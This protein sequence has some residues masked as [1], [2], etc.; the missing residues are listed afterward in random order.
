MIF[1]DQETEK[2]DTPVQL[3]FH[4][5]DRTPAFIISTD[6]THASIDLDKLT[7]PPHPAKVALR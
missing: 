4:T 7:F 2:I 1:I 6:P 5:A 3:L